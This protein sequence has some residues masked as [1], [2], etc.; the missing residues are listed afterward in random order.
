MMRLMSH[1]NLHH[2]SVW[3]GHGYDR[4]SFDRWNRWFD[5]HHYLIHEWNWQKVRHSTKFM[6]FWHYV[7]SFETTHSETTTAA[8]SWNIRS[9]QECQI[10]VR[11]WI[12]F[13][14]FFPKRA[15]SSK[16][17]ANSCT[18]PGYGKVCFVA[19][20]WI[21]FEYNKKVR[22]LQFILATKRLTMILF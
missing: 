1:S 22:S 21:W 18:V 16:Y 11:T 4:N 9:G 13:A 17:N 20:G 14:S 12:P 2:R 5:N 7:G 10:T 15:D 6:L 3:H 8:S 19:G